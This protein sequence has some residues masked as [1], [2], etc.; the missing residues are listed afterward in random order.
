MKSSL[1]LGSIL[2]LGCNAADQA[3]LKKD[4]TKLAESS[5]RSLGNAGLAA[6]VNTVLNLRKGVD[7]STFSVESEAGTITLKGTIPTLKAKK[8][9]LEL[10]QE[11]KGVEKTVDKLQIKP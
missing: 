3:D 6:K 9:I 7:T 11:T 2:M 4:A 8:L 10:V 1:L 5:T